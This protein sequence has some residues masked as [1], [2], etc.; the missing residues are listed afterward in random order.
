MQILI[1]M[2]ALRLESKVI[3]DQHRYSA[4]LLQFALIRIG[5]SRRMQCLRHGAVVAASKL[6]Q[7]FYLLCLNIRQEKCKVITV[8]MLKIR[9]MHLSDM[10]SLHEIAK[11]TGLSRNTLRSCL[12]KPERYRSRCTSAP[13][14]QKAQWLCR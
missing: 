10:V 13:G 5:G 14:V 3:N 4:E 9:R 7:V 8:E 1:R 11:R 6:T 2:C 12:R